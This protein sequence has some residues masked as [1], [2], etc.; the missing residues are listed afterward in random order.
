VWSTID[1]RDGLPASRVLKVVQAADGA[2]WLATSKGLTRYA[3]PDRTPALLRLR[4]QLDRDHLN[5]AQLPEVTSG[6]RIE[7]HFEV[8]DFRSRPGNRWFQHLVAPGVLSLAE[9]ETHP[10]WSAPSRDPS[11]EQPAPRPGAYTF[12]VRYIDCDLNRSPPRV[13]V[14]TV[15]PP[16]HADWR[17]MGPLA[18]GNAALLTLAVLVGQRARARRQ[19]TERLREAM[20]RQEQAARLALEKEVLERRKAEEAAEA[21]S[22]AKSRF[23]ATMSHELRTPLNAILGYAEMVQEELQATGHTALVPDLE[24]IGAAAR[25]QL[26]L[27]NDILDLARI[28]AGKSSLLVEEFPVAKLVQEVAA[29]V[30]PLIAKRG[31]RLETI[32]PAELGAMRSDATKLRQVLFNLLSNAAKFSERG[33]VTL[34]VAREDGRRESTPGASAQPEGAPEATEQVGASKSGVATA[35]FT[36]QVADTGIGMTPDQVGRLFQAFSQAEQGTHSRYGG[37]GLGL[38]ISRKFCQM[39][40]GDLT[41]TSEAGK[42]STFTAVL[43][44]VAPNAPPG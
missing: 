40:G 33:L 20:L 36:F 34:R 3:P 16:W 38:A 42:G 6:R 25:H 39:M 2:T 31:N 8:T 14:L 43:P 1:E 21:A 24:R 44:A 9:V 10:G 27:V 37:T 5:P 15:V 11:H 19:E 18:G 17:I 22:L 35:W 26:T 28:E 23:L 4:V 41:V 32:C 13:T 30:Q 12:A 29:T 7:F